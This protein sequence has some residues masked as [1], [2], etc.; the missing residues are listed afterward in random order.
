MEII[1]GSFLHLGAEDANETPEEA[2]KRLY[3]GVEKRQV[4]GKNGMQGQIV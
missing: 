2:Q 4:A 1:L 3:T